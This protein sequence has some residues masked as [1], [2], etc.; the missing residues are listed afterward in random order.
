MP[1]AT[2]IAGAVFVG[3][4]AAFDVIATLLHS[5]DLSN[6]ANPVARF[7]LDSGHSVTF[8]LVYGALCQ[9]LLTIGSIFL[10][11]A[12]LSQRVTIVDSVRDSSPTFPKFMK[13]ILGGANK[14]WKQIFFPRL[15]RYHG[16]RSARYFYTLWVLA[17]LLVGGAGFRWY[18]GL[19]WFGFSPLNREFVG[20]ASMLLGLAGYFA[21][22]WRAVQRAN[23]RSA[24]AEAVL[25]S[26]GPVMDGGRAVE[27]AD[28]PS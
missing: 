24:I 1:L 17:A 15:F 26:D 5:P 2:F 8:V 22:T 18:L 11:G 14:S 9:T 27:M 7:L 21:W 12:L 23:D 25:V 16:D 13:A 6:E 28:D 20:V 10:W 19:E 4:G 3:G